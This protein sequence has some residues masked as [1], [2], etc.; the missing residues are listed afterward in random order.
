[1]GLSHPLEAFGETKAKYHDSVPET[2]GI[3]TLMNIRPNLQIFSGKTSSF[4]YALACI[5][6]LFWGIWTFHRVEFLTGFH[7][8]PGDIGDSRF[9]MYILENYYQSFLGHAKI[10]SPAMFYP[11]QGLLG[12]NDANS[13]AVPIYSLFRF[14]HLDMYDAFQACA[15]ACDVFAWFTCFLLFKKGLGFGFFPSSV[16]ASFYCFN[17]IRYNQTNHFDL[18]M[19]FLLPLILMG[20]AWIYRN[21]VRA[22]DFQVFGVLSVTAFL[23]GV[24]FLTSFYLA[25]FFCFWFLILVLTMM[26]WEENRRKGWEFL[27]R[28][29]LS[30][31]A[32]AGVFLFSLIPALALYL[33]ALQMRGPR[34]FS[35]AAEAAPVPKA[36]FWMGE[37][38]W[39]WGWLARFPRLATIPFEWENRL[40]LGLVFILFWIVAGVFL[41]GRSLNF[42]SSNGIRKSLTFSGERLK[43]LEFP[44]YLSVLISAAFV[45]RIFHHNYLWEMVYHLIPGA[46]AMKC[47]SRL[48][49]VLALPASCILT[50]ETQRVADWIQK[51]RSSTHKIYAWTL[52]AI[53]LGLIW[54][55]QMGDL[56]FPGYPKDRDR[57]RITAMAQTI[58]KEA[59]YFYV[60]L[61][62]NLKDRIRNTHQVDAMLVSMMSGIPTLNGYNSTTPPGWNLH[63]NKQTYEWRLKQW[64]MYNHLDSP[65]YRLEI[66]DED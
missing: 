5:I 45:V 30:F 4:F 66:K 48:F 55:E 18:Q 3:L 28:F 20:F 26:I 6:P 51:K 60:V 41:L 2:H 56:P 38:N 47:I 35:D 14:A 25:W 11:A 23:L 36:L 37:Q 57:E 46:S 16:G 39:F 62:P 64:L 59:E 13:A 21:A 54:F 65:G 27:K 61:G 29:R 43:T 19:Q 40:G 17:N 24:Q 12:Y 8:M 42:N 33:P 34:A 7:F 53:F 44:V 22:G 32:S 15:M 52:L 63:F 10:L 50:S 1:M 49:L 9:C 58:P 31:A